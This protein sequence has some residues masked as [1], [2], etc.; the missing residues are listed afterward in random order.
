MNTRIIRTEFPADAGQFIDAFMNAYEL[1]STYHHADNDKYHFVDVEVPC[2]QIIN[3]SFN[4]GSSVTLARFGSTTVFADSIRLLE[5]TPEAYTMIMSYKGEC[6]ALHYFR[7]PV[8]SAITVAEM[9]VEE[10]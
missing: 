9:E 10:N 2:E 7:F 4:A 3:L 1:A 6:V 5:T 8:E